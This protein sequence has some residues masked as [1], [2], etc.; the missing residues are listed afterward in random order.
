MQPLRDAQS[1]L[2]SLAAEEM[3]LFHSGDRSRYTVRGP[4][5]GRMELVHQLYANGMHSIPL[6]LGM[7]RWGK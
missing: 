2:E 6:E 1:V 3:E 4:L 7:W 5:L